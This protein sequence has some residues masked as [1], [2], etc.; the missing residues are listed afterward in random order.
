MSSTW[1]GLGS[2]VDPGNLPDDVCWDWA[3]NGSCPRGRKC[4]WRHSM[5]EAADPGGYQ[6]TL[7]DVPY[8]GDQAR[9][10]RP[11]VTNS[12][13][14]RGKGDK[15]GDK[16]GAREV[17]ND[18]APPQL[19]PSNF[20]SLAK[21]APPGFADLPARP[22]L[23]Q[24]GTTSMKGTSKGAVGKA[25][26]DVR[27]DAHKDVAEDFHSVDGSNSEIEWPTLAGP[28]WAD[29]EISHNDMKVLAKTTGMQNQ[30]EVRKR[31][32]RGRSP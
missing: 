32:T 10:L 28:S 3:K 29:E 7:S 2:Y 19:A 16:R 26:A 22:S 20:P 12:H 23:D 27:K 8:A 24:K 25:K 31:P 17:K 4:T 13:Q 5:G 1:A 21:R 15:K 30:P 6:A 14:K 9:D 18:R 11:N